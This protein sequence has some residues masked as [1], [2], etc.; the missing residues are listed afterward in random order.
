MVCIPVKGS[1]NMKSLIL[2]AF[3]FLTSYSC[4][5]LDLNELSPYMGADAQIRR[6]N[7]RNGYGKNLFQ[8]NVPQG[9]LYFG[10]R[11]NE[12]FGVEAGY[13]STKGKSKLKSFSFV[14]GDISLGVKVPFDLSILYK[15]KIIIKG[16]HLD[17]VGF[18]PLYQGS[19]L[20][21]IY[22]GGVA[23]FRGYGNRTILLVNEYPT[24]IV[25]VSEN[26]RPILRMGSGLQYR[27]NDRISLRST[28]TWINTSK[29]SLETKD[30]P[31]DAPLKPVVKLKDNINY[32]VGVL[33][34]F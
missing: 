4:N 28:V 9:N 29:I 31:R 6:I 14:K 13:E 18:Y 16:L 8:N 27:L 10:V 33:F 22:Y 21:F 32:S 5:S 11:L 7:F 3:V 25:R 12:Y 1:F 30:I 34:A 26:H 24:H 19:N 15:T 20:E 2:A 23:F 17:L